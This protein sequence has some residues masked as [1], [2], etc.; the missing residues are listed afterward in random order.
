[1][2]R[3]ANTRQSP[4]S[5]SWPLLVIGAFDIDAFLKLPQSISFDQELYP[6]LEDKAA[7]VFYTLNK[8]HIFPD[9]S[10]VGVEGM[11]SLCSSAPRHVDLVE[12]N[13]DAV[14]QLLRVVNGLIANETR[15]A[16]SA[17]VP[18]GHLECGEA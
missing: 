17:A 6:T 9:A 15:V 18:S 12:G 16:K 1:M 13:A 14:G 4:V 5:G 2:W 3:P 11:G 10:R 8:K 7:I